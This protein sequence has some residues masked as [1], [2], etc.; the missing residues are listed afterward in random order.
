MKKGIILIFVLV[1]LAQLAVP[2]RMITDKE[3]VISDGH[4]YKFR[5]APIDPYDP[6]RGKY[7][8]LTFDANQ[9]DIANDNFWKQD[10][11]V[12]V[13]LG[14]DSAGFAKITDLTKQEPLNGKADYVK[15][16]IQYVY[17]DNVTISYP[18][19]KFFMEE[20]KAPR[21]EDIYRRANRRDSVQLAY[22]LVSVK[23]GDA[24]LKDVIINEV[25]ISELAKEH[26]GQ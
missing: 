26:A 4:V 20:S 7:I 8:T 21:A 14:T 1:A 25:S 24:V 15:A 5:T 22:A 9:F 11:D 19:D 16:K 6:F 10:D 2:I 23:G 12:Y 13:L 17:G 3:N 18:F